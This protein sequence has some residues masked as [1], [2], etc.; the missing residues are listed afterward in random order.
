M[1]RAKLKLELISNSRSRRITFEKRKKG[2]MK[3]AEEFK[4]LCGVDT[5]VMIYPMGMSGESLVEPEIWPP[6]GK[7]VERIVRRYRSEAADRRAKHATGLREFFASRKRKID[8]ELAEVRK[9][10]REAKYPVLDGFLKDLS[11]PQLRSLLSAVGDRLEQAKTRL[12]TIKEKRRVEI[13]APS[14]WFVSSGGVDLH[15]S[16]A[17]FMQDG[18]VKAGLSFEFMYQQD[19]EKRRVETAAPS[20][21]TVPSGGVDL[22]TSNAVFMQDSAV[23]AGLPFESLYQQDSLVGSIHDYSLPLSS[24]PPECSTQFGTSR[25]DYSWCRTVNEVQIRA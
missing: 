22:H 17:G 16:S 23:E 13:S 20:D 6:D 2:L 3:K 24:L 25:G 9:A 10:N 14:D 15:A 5:C 8:A 12:A 19:N 21:W 11:E 18:M 7:E 1:G 4:I